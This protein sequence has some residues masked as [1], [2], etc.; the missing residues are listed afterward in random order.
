MST[1]QASDADLN[2]EDDT[3]EVIE[4]KK[5]KPN[6]TFSTEMMP[7][8]KL[9]GKTKSLLNQME[10]SNQDLKQQI[11][12]MGAESVS[13]ENFD[14]VQNDKQKPYIDL[15]LYLGIMEETDEKQQQKQVQ[16]TTDKLLGLNQPTNNTI[17]I[18]ANDDDTCTTTNS[19]LKNTDSSDDQDIDL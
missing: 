6:M 4:I 9:L 16:S 12:K 18:E 13:I 19:S 8:S 17:I 14:P 11:D 5:K 10:K 2:T 1:N 15:D 7:R 3:V